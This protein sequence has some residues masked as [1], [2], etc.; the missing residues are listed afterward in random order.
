[1]D[2]QENEEVDE[3]VQMEED[4]LNE[5]YPDDYPVVIHM[6]RKEVLPLVLLPHLSVIIPI[7]PTVSW[8]LES[9]QACGCAFSLTCYSSQ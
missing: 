3:D 4:Q 7:L 6:L 2:D 8:F 1:M 9:A 5:G